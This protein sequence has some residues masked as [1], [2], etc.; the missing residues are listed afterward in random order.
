MRWLR[1]FV[2]DLWLMTSRK[3]YLE[4][5]KLVWSWFHLYSLFTDKDESRNV[6]FKS[7]HHSSLHHLDSVSSPSGFIFKCV[8]NLKS[9]EPFMLHKLHFCSVYGVMSHDN[10]F[11]IW[12]ANCL[13]FGVFG[14]HLKSSSNINDSLTR[15]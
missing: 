9:S 14:P 7:N 4:V 11:S 1:C 13:A 5:D 12:L 6:F 3:V 15:F 8:N 2:K 10:I